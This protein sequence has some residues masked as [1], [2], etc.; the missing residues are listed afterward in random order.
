VPQNIGYVALVVRDYDEAISY[1]TEKLGFELIE[2]SLSK[3][4]LGRNKRWVL[5]RPSGSHGT[6]LL[7]AKASSPDEFSHVGNQ[8]GNRV[9]LFLHTDDFWRDYRAMAARGVK[10][11][12]TPREESY[13][14]VVVFEDLY[15]NKWDL[16]CL[17]SSLG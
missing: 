1:F 14:T 9:S 10:F 15:G 3:D 16:L 8:T 11:L 4:R 2:D 13:G 17:S 12:D 6:S 7:L 5:V